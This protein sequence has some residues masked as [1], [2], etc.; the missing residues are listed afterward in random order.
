MDGAGVAKLLESAADRGLDML[1]EFV[2]SGL[3]AGRLKMFFEDIG[4][5]EKSNKSKHSDSVTAADV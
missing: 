1:D 3:K 5:L 2:L 4:K